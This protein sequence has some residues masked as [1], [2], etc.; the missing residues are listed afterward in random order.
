M[1]IY[2]FNSKLFDSKNETFCSVD[3]T[4]L[5]LERVTQIIELCQTMVYQIFPNSK[6]FSATVSHSMFVVK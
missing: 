5:V 2:T 1:Q 6:V 3:E 4:D